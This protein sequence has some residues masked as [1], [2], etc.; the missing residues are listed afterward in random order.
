MILKPKPK[1]KPNKMMSTFMTACV[2]METECAA[3][4]R[5]ISE[6]EFLYEDA[7]AKLAATKKIKSKNKDK[8]IPCACGGITSTIPSI[9]KTHEQ[10]KKHQMMMCQFI[11]IKEEDD[12]ASVITVSGSEA[13]VFED[14]E[15]V[16]VPHV[17]E[18]D[19]D[20]ELAIDTI[21]IKRYPASVVSYD[22][23]VFEEEEDV[24]QDASAKAPTTYNKA[25]YESACRQC[26]CGGKTSSIKSFA[27]RHEASKHH[28]KYLAHYG[29]SSIE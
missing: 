8:N 18:P 29:L 21:H 28:Q 24:F 10:T 14:Y 1:P 9:A 6:L 19:A 22:D 16:L 26:L 13:S 4:D 11:D 20:D 3:K 5:R 27:K 7:I 23:E 12:D 15:S 25:R 2:A 17:E